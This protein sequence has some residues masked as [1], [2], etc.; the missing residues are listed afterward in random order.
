LA[1]V[2]KHNLTVRPVLIQTVFVGEMRIS[3]I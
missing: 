3:N 2:D 1:F